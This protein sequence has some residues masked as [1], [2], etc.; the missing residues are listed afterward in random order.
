EFGERRPRD[1]AD[2]GRRQVRGD[3][4][5]QMGAGEPQLSAGEQFRRRPASHDQPD[6]ADLSLTTL[7]GVDAERLV[8]GMTQQ[9]PAAR[10]GALCSRNMK[11]YLRPE[12][13]KHSE[14]PLI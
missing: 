3:R 8:A 2:L 4:P 9:S 1:R 10:L 5:R 6:E 12:S 11:R 13:G 7:L 14:I